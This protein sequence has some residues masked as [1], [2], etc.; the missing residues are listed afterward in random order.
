MEKKQTSLQRSK[1]HGNKKKRLDRTIGKITSTLEDISKK[2]M[3]LKRTDSRF[4]YKDLQLQKGYYAFHAELK[5]YQVELDECT[6]VLAEP[7]LSER[8]ERLEREQEA[9][10]IPHKGTTWATSRRYHFQ[11]QKRLQ[12]VKKELDVVM[13]KLE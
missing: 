8:M 7:K 3:A 9:L 1:Q 6:T 13:E 12:A 11:S 5:K 4:E 2:A 10:E